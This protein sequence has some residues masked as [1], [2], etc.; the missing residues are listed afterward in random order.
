M[1]VNM[2]RPVRPFIRFPEQEKTKKKK[3]R[4]KEG[5]VIRIDGPRRHD[6]WDLLN[7]EGPE[8]VLD[9][10]RRNVFRPEFISKNGGSQ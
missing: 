8:K 7:D 5:T 6:T 1:M 3:T 2:R 9:T 4:R 10:L